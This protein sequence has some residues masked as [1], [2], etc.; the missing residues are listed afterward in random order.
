[1]LSADAAYEPLFSDDALC[2]VDKVVS[3]EYLLFPGAEFGAENA[4]KV[5]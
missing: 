5:N 3:S 2:V 4:S 1:M